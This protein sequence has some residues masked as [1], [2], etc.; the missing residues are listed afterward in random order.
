MLTEAAGRSN[1][2]LTFGQVGIF[3]SSKYVVNIYEERFITLTQSRRSVLFVLLSHQQVKSPVMAGRPCCQRGLIGRSEW[4]RICRFWSALEVGVGL[5]TAARDSLPSPPNSATNSASGLY[6]LGSP[7]KGR[8]VPGAE[9]GGVFGWSRASRPVGRCAD[10][11]V[12][13]QPPTSGPASQEPGSKAAGPAPEPASQSGAERRSLSGVSCWD[14]S[15]QPRSPGNTF[16]WSSTTLSQDAQNGKTSTD[17]PLAVAVT[18][19][20]NVGISSPSAVLKLP[21]FW[22]L[23]INHMQSLALRL[24][25]LRDLTDPEP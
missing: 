1:G 24:R 20:S 21:F 12:Q 11:S 2:L 6:N 13:A 18:L 10:G 19:A 25:F 22:R 9:V 8:S 4:A 5:L 23:L 15:L 16:C 3:T 7:I 14:R 17:A